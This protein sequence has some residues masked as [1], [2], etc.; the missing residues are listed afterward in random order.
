MNFKRS[1][2]T[3]PNI[4]RRKFVI[5]R[6]N[7]NVVQCNITFFFIFAVF[8]VWHPYDLTRRCKPLVFAFYICCF[9]LVNKHIIY[10][11]CNKVSNSSFE[12]R[13]RSRD[14]GHAHLGSFYDPDAVGV[15]DLCMCQIWSGYLYW[16]KSYK[17]GPKISKFGHVTLSHA[18]L[19]LKH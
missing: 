3:F 8:V 19:N 10:L 11:W 15:R 12:C 1:K 5:H 17:G 7:V 14:P 2:I 9:V 16:F 4:S 13:I 18:P 6:Q